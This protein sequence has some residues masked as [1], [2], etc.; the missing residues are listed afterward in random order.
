MSPLLSV[1]LVLLLIPLLAGVALLYARPE[2]LIVAFVMVVEAVFKR[3]RVGA[4]GTTQ[5]VGQI[6]VWCVV[7]AVAA[8][9]LWWI[10]SYV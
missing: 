7:A 8:L 6:A 9:F 1:L 5:R 3:R 4:Y 10:S 2:I